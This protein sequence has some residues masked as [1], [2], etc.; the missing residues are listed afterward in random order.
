MSFSTTCTCNPLRTSAIFAT[1]RQIREEVLRLYYLRNH[2]A[3]EPPRKGPRGAIKIINSIPLSRLQWITNLSIELSAESGCK[4]G[5]K[6]WSMDQDEWLNPAGEYEQRWKEWAQLL[7]LLS[8][9]FQDNLDLSL[10]F[11]MFSV[12][13]QEIIGQVKSRTRSAF[14]RLITMFEQKGLKKV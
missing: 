12:F 2:F 5:E 11:K 9:C 3:I 10:D 14:Q 13:P 8:T 6:L 4:P 7:Q 1:S